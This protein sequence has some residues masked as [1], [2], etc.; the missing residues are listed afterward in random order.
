M[1][2]QAPCVTR[3]LAARFFLDLADGRCA[4]ERHRRSA[5]LLH[6]PDAI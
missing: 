4:S 3:V 1:R 2:A 5:A 6:L